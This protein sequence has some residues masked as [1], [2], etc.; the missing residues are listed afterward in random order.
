MSI[1]G[2]II[3]DDQMEDAVTA[4]LKK[5]LPTHLSEIETQLGLIRGHHER[6]ATWATRNDFEKFPEEMLPLVIVISAGLID[7]PAKTGKGVYRAKW[8]IGVA[9]VATSIDQENARKNAY[10]LGAAARAVLIQ[11]QSLDGA[12][13]G[14]IRGVDWLDSTNDELPPEGSRTIFATKQVFSVE[15]DDVLTRGSGP[16]DPDPLDETPTPPPYEDWE[17][18]PDRDHVQMTWTKEPIE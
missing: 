4:V 2:T 5:W 16:K 3:V 6:P 13:G 17:T 9:T 11:R 18:I 12:L 1:F 10:R 8:G 7:D 14:R 15:V